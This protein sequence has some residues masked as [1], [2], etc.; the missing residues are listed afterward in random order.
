MRQGVKSK[1]A[2]GSSLCLSLC[3]SLGF[4]LQHTEHVAGSGAPSRA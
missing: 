2:G 1:G 3:L 4:S